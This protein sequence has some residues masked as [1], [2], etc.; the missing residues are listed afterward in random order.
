MSVSKKSQK[1]LRQSQN[2]IIV[3]LSHDTDQSK[4][5]PCDDGRRKAAGAAVE[6]G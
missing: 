5:P 4:R 3:V 6:S 1:D 2:W